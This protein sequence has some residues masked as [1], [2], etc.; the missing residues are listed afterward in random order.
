MKMV[1]AAASQPDMLPGMILMT[2]L[3]YLNTS[4]QWGSVITDPPDA[5]T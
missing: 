2:R 4:S 3:L 1:I 5:C